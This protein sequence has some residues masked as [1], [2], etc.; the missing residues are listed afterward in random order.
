VA[1]LLGGKGMNAMRYESLPILPSHDGPAR[2]LVPHLYFWKSG[3]WVRRLRFMEKNEPGF[4]ESHGI[5]ALGLTVELIRDG[6]VCDHLVNELRRGDKF[7]VSGPIGRRFVWTVAEGGPLF[8]I[9]GGSGMLLMSM[10]PHRQRQARKVSA[11]LVYSRC[12]HADIIYRAELQSL[13]ADPA[14]TLTITLTRGAPHS[15]CGPSRR[16]DKAM[17]EEAG[18][19]PETMPQIF[20]CGSNAIVEA[21]TR[22]P[23]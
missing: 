18:F 17:L 4:W 15:W 12:T 5:D 13:A 23:L 11:A 1:D 6:E 19:G 7:E 16:I 22:I 8:L 3:K 20:I 10:L 21:A 14:F 9:G 2:L